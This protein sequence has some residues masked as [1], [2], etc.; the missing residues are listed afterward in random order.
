MVAGGKDD[1]DTAARL[2]ELFGAW[3]D[4]MPAIIAAT[5]QTALTPHAWS[6]D[7]NRQTGTGRL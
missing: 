5:P 1:G 7:D 2:R 4:P 6:A 3:H